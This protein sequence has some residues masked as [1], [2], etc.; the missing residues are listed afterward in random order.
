MMRVKNH[1]MPATILVDIA[2][3]ENKHSSSKRFSGFESMSTYF[4][5]R[6]LPCCIKDPIVNH[7][8]LTKLKSL[9]RTSVSSRQGWGLSHSYGLNLKT[10]AFV[11][12]C[13]DFY[14]PWSMAGNSNWRTWLGWRAGP[15]RQD[16]QW[17]CKSKR[18]A[19][20]GTG[21]RTSLAA[22]S[23]VSWTKCWRLQGRIK[24]TKVVHVITE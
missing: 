1:H 23:W 19:T 24:L 3:E 10:A 18:P 11:L 7:I 4:G 22:F 16:M 12:I 5:D 13:V 9:M 14:A 20:T 15:R 6:S 8:E 21:R 2:L 17:P